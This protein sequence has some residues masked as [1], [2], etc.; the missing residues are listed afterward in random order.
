MDKRDQSVFNLKSNNDAYKSENDFLKNEFI[1]LIGSIPSMEKGGFAQEEIAA[2][3][4]DGKISELELQTLHDELAELKRL[5]EMNEAKISNLKNEN[6][7]LNSKLKNL[8]SVFI[9]GELIRNQDGTVTNE[10]GENYNISSIM[11]E[12]HELRKALDKV[13]IDKLELKEILTKKENLGHSII[14][15]NSEYERLKEHNIK[16]SRRVEFLQKRER[17]LLETIMRL[18]MDASS[19][20]K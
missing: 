7:I 18:K 14:N 3:K 10:M 6:G 4:S 8:E 2:F 17:E 9:G 13:E 12:N 20:R 16:L 11:L 5:K 15:E 1:K 19:N